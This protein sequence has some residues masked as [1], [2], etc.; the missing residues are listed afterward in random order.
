MDDGTAVVGAPQHNANAGAAYVFTRN[1]VSGK[2]S[3]P[4]ELTAGSDGAAHDQFGY[5]VA[6]DGDT[7]VVGAYQHNTDGISDA[8]AA[9]VFTWDSSSRAWSEPVKLIADDGGVDDREDDWF[10]YSVAVHEGVIVVGARGVGGNIGAAYVFIRPAAGWAAIGD[11]TE[12]KLTASDGGASDYFG[13]SVAVHGDTIVVGARGYGQSPGAAYVF[14]TSDAWANDSPQ[15]KLTAS[16]GKNGDQFGYSVAVNGDTVVVGAQRHDRNKGSAYVFT[17]PD[18]GWVDKTETAKL[19]PSDRDTDDYF[20]SSV[21]VRGGTIVVGAPLADIYPDNGSNSGAAYIFTQTKPAN[22]N[23]WSNDV[24]EDHKTETAKLILPRGEGVD[25]EDDKFGHS[26][27]LD[28]QSILVGAPQSDYMDAANDDFGSVY[29]SNIPAWTRIPGSEA[30]TTSHRVRG[31]TNSV[32][33]T[34]QVRAVDDEGQGLASDIV[35][36]TPFRTPNNPPTFGNVNSITRTVDE[37]APL[38]THVGSAV[39]ATDPDRGTLTYSLSG[40]D[41][42]SFGIDDSTGQLTVL[43]PLDFEAKSVYQMKVWAYD[44]RNG[45][46]VVDLTIQV[47]NLDEL[48]TAVVSP[49]YPEVGSALTASLSD[50]DGS[51]S[52]ISWQWARSSDSSGWSN[53]PR[54]N[55]EVYTPVAD[56]V[57]GYLRAE[58]F[59]TDGHGSDKSA[60]AVLGRQTAQRAPSFEED[61][62]T[63]SVDEN[64]LLGTLVGSAITAID[65][66][67]VI[68]TYS[69]SGTDAAS[70]VIDSSIGQITLGSETVIDYESGPARYTVIV[71]VSDG[72]DAYGNDDPTIDDQIEVNIVVINLEEAGTVSVSP[73]QPKIGAALTVSLSDPD[74]SLPDISW[75]WARSA[76]GSNWSD[77][78]GTDSDTYTPVADDAGNY[79]RATAF[80]TDGHGSG[81]SAY[82]VLGRQT[83]QRAPSFEED[84]VTFSVD[85]NTPPGTL[86]GTALKAT[87]QDG[88]ILTYSLSGTDAASFV[89]DGS[90]GQITVGSE[91]V[92]DYESGPA[93]YSVVVSVSDGKDAYGND[94]PAIDDQIEVNIDL[95]NI[96][97]SGTVSLSQEQAKVGAALTVSLSDPDGSLS[98]ISW[99]WARSSDG[100]NWADITGASSSTYTPVDQD[101]DKYLRITASYVDGAGF[102][103]QA[104]AVMSNP[105]GKLPVPLATSTPT[106]TPQPTAIPTA[107]PPPTVIPS[108]TSTPLA[109]PSPTPA[110]LATPS[111]TPEPMPTTPIVT[112][113]DEGA[114]SPWWI[115]LVV[116]GAVAVATGIYMI[117]RNHG[118]RRSQRRG[119]R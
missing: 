49:E 3:N 80:Y 33:Y 14:T 74:G 24:N 43:D 39:T 86:V 116:G 111:P 26:V 103:K 87:D 37:N 58:A 2:W 75:Q 76:D 97:E 50:P 30:T 46:D 66:D 13:Q 67:D 98:D 114:L 21:A 100:S 59:Y 36:A 25:E 72:R 54:A 104:R 106:P 57:A 8:G 109:T 60:D 95:K 1:P 93:R 44:N 62:I 5:S 42:S 82:A 48:G 16:D 52:D 68:L 92:I 22:A 89:I 118:P 102:G 110:P 29:V 99:Q 28:G 40:T 6:V 119:L 38:G 20:G 15:V 10:G 51:L 17:K 84:T 23:D 83:A 96:D 47:T 35:R 12:V 101:A 94:D 105:V 53:I 41:A 91:T 55:S 34:F 27:A 79:L 65:P 81:K 71:S 31:L 69:L 117:V 56:D 85:E 63:F 113:V 7:I 77:I 9:Y 32:E 4:I 90:T 115:I 108:P 73:E 45:R 19:T 112:P 64:A 78:P 88:V 11:T 107:E 70:F 18:G 61:S